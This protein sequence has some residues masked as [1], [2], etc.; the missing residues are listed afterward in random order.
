MRKY[1]LAAGTLWFR[2][3]VRFVRQPN[4]IV[5]ALGTPLLFWLIIGSGLGKSFQAAGSGTAGYLEYFF[6]GTLAL[7]A[8]FTAIFSTISIIEDRQ[9][10]FLQSVLVAPVPRSAVTL[11][12]IMGAT[13]LAVIQAVIF[14]ALAPAIGIS[15]DVPRLLALVGV[16]TLMGFSLSALGYLIAWRME[17]TQD[18]HAIMNLLLIPLWLLSGALF[19]PAGAPVWIRG[20]IRANPLTYGITA[21]RHILYST[22]QVESGLPSLVTCLAVTALF[23]IASFIATTLVADKK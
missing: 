16:L 22:T 23:C 9:V 12:K 10:G 5:G 15:L 21:V 4:R 17:S 18:F 19:P 6:P 7:I 3:I 2:E 11:G 1:S 13:T 8:L 14:L 20:I